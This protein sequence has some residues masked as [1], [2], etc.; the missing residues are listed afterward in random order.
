MTKI[1]IVGSYPPRYG[2]ISIHIQRLH[3]LLRPVSDC[4]VYDL[5]ASGGEPNEPGVHRIYGKS[6]QRVL[7]CGE[8]LRKASSDIEHIHVSAM[9]KFLWGTPVLLGR[10]RQGKRILTI[11]GGA[12][13][14][15]I[16]SLAV[17]ERVIFH[18]ML[19]Q[20]DFFVCV[21]EKQKQVLLDWGVATCK[22]A[23]IN[24]YLPPVR[25]VDTTPFAN[26]LA[27]KEAGRPILICTASYLEHY[28]VVELLTAL[29]ALSDKKN[30]APCLVFVNYLDVDEPYKK[31][32]KELMKGLDVFEYKEIDPSQLSAL[33][34]IGDIF[35]RPTWWDG[36]AVSVR[37]ASFF[38]NRIVASDVTTRPEGSH[39]FKSKSS[40]SL[41]QALAEAL[42]N[43]NLG[44]VNFNHFDSMHKLVKVYNQLGSNISV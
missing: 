24:A 35:V 44:K 15:V 21:S 4:H 9:R 37:E 18:W 32:C 10:K 11:H 19:K 22:I 29:Q 5:Y 42:E 31:R 36:D 39:L 26:V 12:F 41:A 6:M 27:A 30:S 28:G 25:E 1:S 38:G 16:A 20:F 23:I 17:W 40:E 43:P 33:M 34:S 2:G 7:R 8:M 3:K 13:P 14:E